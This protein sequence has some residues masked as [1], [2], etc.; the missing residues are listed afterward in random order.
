MFP[1]DYNRICNS[2]GYMC[3]LNALDEISSD[4]STSEL[5]GI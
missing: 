1:I 2:Y 4:E 5:T 3:D